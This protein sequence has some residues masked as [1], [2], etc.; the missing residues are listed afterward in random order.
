MSEPIDDA[1]EDCP[2]GRPDM[3]EPGGMLTWSKPLAPPVGV[4]PRHLWQEDNP[5]PSDDELRARWVDLRGAILRYLVA[6]ESSRPCVGE[7]QQ[8][9]DDIQRLL[10]ARRYKH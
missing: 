6:N 4:Y 2:I 8:E 7:W 9:I 1:V 10:A 5:D 3:C